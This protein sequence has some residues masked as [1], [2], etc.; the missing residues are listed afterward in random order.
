MTTKRSLN[1]CRDEVSK[2]NTRAHRVSGVDLIAFCLHAARDDKQC[3]ARRAAPQICLVPALF[4]SSTERWLIS[5]VYPPS[6]Q[7]LVKLAISVSRRSPAYRNARR[8]SESD[9]VVQVRV[10]QRLC[11]S[12]WLTTRF[13]VSKGHIHRVYASIR[14]TCVS[15]RAIGPDISRFAR[16]FVL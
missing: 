13:S 14:L 5:S 12:K 9:I 4:P 3:Q 7:I 15:I 8:V 10:R 6:Q 16:H 11:S 1:Q 2:M